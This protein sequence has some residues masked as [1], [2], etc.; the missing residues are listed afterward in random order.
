MTYS[1][2]EEELGKH[3]GIYGELGALGMARSE[4]EREQSGDKFKMGE[5][6]NPDTAKKWAKQRSNHSKSNIASARASFKKRGL[7]D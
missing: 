3:P 5:E 1:Q 2:L 7:I 4:Y 6:V